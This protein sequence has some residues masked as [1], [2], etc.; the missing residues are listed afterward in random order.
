[1]MMG[2]MVLLEDQANPVMSVALENGLEVTALHNHFFWDSPKVMFMHIGGTGNPEALATAV[3]KVFS[4]IKE[5]SNG[6]GEKPFFETDPS[7][8]TLDPK[9]IED[10][11]GKKGELN[12]GVYLWPLDNDEWS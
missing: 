4:T 10:I 9:K 11:L 12:K 3:G 7:K 8:T 6:K 1:M 2:D 5:T